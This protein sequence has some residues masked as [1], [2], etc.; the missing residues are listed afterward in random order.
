[1][2]YSRDDVDKIS[3]E[4]SSP[5]AHDDG[6]VYTYL[7]ARIYSIYQIYMYIESYIIIC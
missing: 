3:T 7:S 6:R 4:K 1:M 2:F 5:P